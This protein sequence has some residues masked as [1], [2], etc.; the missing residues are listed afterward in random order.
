[1]NN[2]ATRKKNIYTWLMLFV[3][4]AIVIPGPTASAAT[5]EE[6][7][8]QIQTLLQQITALQEQIRTTAASPSDCHTFAADLAIG[9]TGAEVTALQQFLIAN[10]YQINA[11]A[12]GYFGGQTQQALVR[13]QADQGIHPAVGYFGPLT[14]AKFQNICATTA[15]KNQQQ[16]RVQVKQHSTTTATTT[17][18]TTDEEQED[19][20]DT[21]SKTPTTKS[22]ELSAV[23]TSVNGTTNDYATFK[24]TIDMHAFGQDV[25][26]PFGTA[27]VSYQLED[28]LGNVIST[29]STAVVTSSADEIDDYFF[30]PEDTNETITLT[31][32]YVP[33]VANTTARL[34]LLG[35]NYSDQPQTP[36]DEWVARP[37]SKYRTK[38]VIIVD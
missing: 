32:T 11:G 26:I 7:Q 8:A 30:I 17:D 19:T 36:D 13:F 2:Y 21:T 31:V 10:G 9:K 1:M 34:H 16:V 20:T 3:L 25:Y 14:R 38:T 28:S 33:G 12:T 6:L 5:M 37:D 27:G 18:D 35:I 24:I 15:A 22:P 23:V 4:A 29:S